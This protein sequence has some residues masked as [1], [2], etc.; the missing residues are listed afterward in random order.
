M[1]NN[2][3]NS[4][5]MKAENVRCSVIGLAAELHIC[6]RMVSMTGGVHSVV[7]DDKHYLEQLNVHIDPPP[8][9]TRLD[10]A[11]VKMGFPHHALQ[12]STAEVSMAVCMW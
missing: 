12:S 1:K 10:A 3:I 2:I 8:A 7:L 6:K 5:S 4:Q 11:L 9:A